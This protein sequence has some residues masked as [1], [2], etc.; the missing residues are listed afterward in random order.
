MTETTYPTSYDIRFA[1]ELD[2]VYM[3]WHGYATSLQFREGTELMLRT[4]IANHATKVFADIKD[5]AIIGMDDQQWLHTDFLPRAIAA[6]F[7]A[8]AIIRPYAYFNKVAV[9]SVSYKVDRSK[10]AI[11]F[12]DNVRSAREWLYGQ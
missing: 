12:F 7:K 3:K 1:P 11:G 6:G 9:E 5:M 4:L 10:L 2:A 8:I